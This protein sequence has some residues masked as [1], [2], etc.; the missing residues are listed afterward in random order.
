[1]G[2]IMPSGWYKSEFT[3]SGNDHDQ[4][5]Y[6]APKCCRRPNH[7]RS[8]VSSIVLPVYHLGIVGSEEDEQGYVKNPYAVEMHGKLSI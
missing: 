4:C 8:G 6:S 2:S 7:G 5:S 3:K 1:M